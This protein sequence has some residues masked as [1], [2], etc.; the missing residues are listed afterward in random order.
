MDSYF[1]IR[2]ENPEPFG[3]RVSNQD[4]PENG[5]ANRHDYLAEKIPPIL[6]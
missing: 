5:Q 1:S 4:K 3:N 2:K 6:L